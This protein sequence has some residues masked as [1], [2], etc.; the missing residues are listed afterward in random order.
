MRRI[1]VSFA[2]VL[3][4]ASRAASAAEP[5]RC[6]GLA[7]FLDSGAAILKDLEADGQQ[8]FMMFKKGAAF[9]ARSASQTEVAAELLRLDPGKPVPPERADLAACVLRRYLVAR[10][11]ERMVAD[12]RTLVEIGR[13][14][15]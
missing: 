15:V 4:L 12:L 10:Y 8:A 7:A 11:G 13:A 1:P 9:A 14:H 2:L 6:D 3:L 5:I